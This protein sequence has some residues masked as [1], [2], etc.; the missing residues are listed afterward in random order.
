MVQSPELVS[1]HN[2][3]PDTGRIFAHR[4]RHYVTLREEGP[5]AERDAAEAQEYTRGESSAGNV[6]IVSARIVRGS[7]RKK[8]SRS[9]ISRDLKTQI[10]QKPFRS[11]TIEPS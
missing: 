2:I 3:R 10:G 1:I 7:L 5:Q 11:R 9:A 6:T 4:E 8:A